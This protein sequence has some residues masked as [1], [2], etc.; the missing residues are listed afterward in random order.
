MRDTYTSVAVRIVMRYDL[1]YISHY[2]GILR[3][4]NT[5]LFANIIVNTA[6]HQKIARNV[7]NKRQRE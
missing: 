6:Y 7:F 1:R 4:R 5:K 3:N 2:E